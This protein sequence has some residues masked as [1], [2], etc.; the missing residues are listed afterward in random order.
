MKILKLLIISLCLSSCA[1]ICKIDSFEIKT[2]SSTIQIADSEFTCK[3][4]EDFIKS[5]KLTTKAIYSEQFLTELKNY[6]KDSISEGPHKKAW[7]NLN[8][9]NIVMSMRK[10][11]NGTHVDTY[12]GIKGWW[13]SFFY[14]NIAF[15]GTENGPIRYNRIPLRKRTIPQISNTLA[16]E[17]A[18]RVGLKHPNSDTNLEIAKKEPPYVIQDIVERIVKKELGEN[19]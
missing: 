17:I 4:K 5:A 1:S 18:H 14:E 12:G 19:K 10:Q 2:D 11:I 8:A 9:N 13:L 3:K 16:H 7:E 15:D 6:M